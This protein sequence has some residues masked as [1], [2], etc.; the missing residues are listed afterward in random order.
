MGPRQEE[1]PKSSS[2]LCQD[3]EELRTRS[4]PGSPTP[5]PPPRTSRLRAVRSPHYCVSP[6]VCAAAGGTESLR[7]QGQVVQ[8]SEPRL[9]QVPNGPP[10]SPTAGRGLRASYLGIPGSLCCLADRAIR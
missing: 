10:G 4:S 8:L 5:A 6:P 2:P 1:T 7:P 9:P 3:T